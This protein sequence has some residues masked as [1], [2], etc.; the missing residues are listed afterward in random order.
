[1]LKIFLCDL[2]HTSQ[3]INAELIPY[4][5]ACIKSDYHAR[6]KN[7]ADIS[8]HKYPERF[9]EEFILVRPQIVGFS[10]YMWNLDLSYTL[11]GAIKALAPDTLIVFGG[12]NYPLEGHR[13]EDWLRS[14]P[15][16]D[17]YVTGE[18]EEPFRNIV[19]T[20]SATGS[21]EAVKRAPLLGTHSLVDGKLHKHTKIRSDGFDDTPRVANLDDTPS[22]YLMGYLDDFLTDP[23]L[24]PLMESNRGC[25]FTCAFCVDGIGARSKIN[26]ASVGRLE[27]EL[28][29]IAQR[30]TGKYL[31][32]ADTNFG[33]Y[34]EDVEFCKVIAGIKEKYDYPHHLQV[35]TGKNKQ[36]RIIECS[37]LLKGSLRLAAAVQS[38]DPEVLRNTK[39]SNISFQQLIEVSKRTSYTQAS[40]YSEIILGLPSDSKHK[41]IDSVCKIVEAGFNQIRM[42]TLMILDGSELATDK[43]RLNFRMKTRFRVVPRSFGVYQFGDKT[44]PSVE[45]EE[46]CVEQETLDLEDYLESRRFAL[47]VTLF[48][49]DCIFDELMQYLRIKHLQVSDWLKFVHERT[50][51]FPPKLAKIYQQFCS[52]TM[53]ELSESREKLEWRLKNETGLIQ[54]YIAG[55]AGN[56]V[57]FNTQ[58]RVYIDAMDELHEVA[59][60]AAREFALGGHVPQSSFDAT[61]LDELQRY[62][63]V[64]KC[65]ITDLQTEVLEGFKFDFVALDSR[66]FDVLPSEL[67]QTEVRFYYE[68]WQKVFFS[69]QMARHGT[70]VQGLGKLMSRVPIKKSQRAV[71]YAADL[72]RGSHAAPTP[73]NESLMFGPIIV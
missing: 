65:K 49:N 67:V 46:V 17:V 21:I 16:V 22:P 54:K 55:E 39:R 9:A 72:Q 28:E 45:V 26:K 12:P 56:N 31:T 6:G 58:A 38:L 37:E 42:H 10:N 59:F 36:A 53:D 73:V 29:Y 27:S 15:A 25:P 34:A 2:T 20:W 63:L 48:Y 24:V 66:N 68:Q 52:E 13:Q 44:F 70:S 30:Y 47:T 69:D 61:Y 71:C 11:A 1:M 5:I 35:S 19:D 57:L 60:E 8:L 18:G 51:V 50:Q 40:T 7:L 4:A 3:G 43:S 14:H 32:L 62:S 64:K 41:F 23:R 33:M